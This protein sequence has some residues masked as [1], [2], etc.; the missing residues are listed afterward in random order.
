M[1]S[2]FGSNAL[3][4]NP[5]NFATLRLRCAPAPSHLRTGPIT[6]R[7][8]WSEIVAVVIVGVTAL[9]VDFMVFRASELKN[10]RRLAMTTP[11][12]SGHK[13]G[14]ANI[15]NGTAAAAAP[16]AAAVVDCNGA[17]A[18]QDLGGVGD[19]KPGGGAGDGRGANAS[20]CNVIDVR[21]ATTT[22]GRSSGGGGTRRN[23]VQMRRVCVLAVWIACAVVFHR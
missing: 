12:P 18:T 2:L 17:T 4:L 7:F 21:L 9:V 11:A 14:S 6:L 23:R 5:L 13:N 3:P 15:A 19:K 22:V 1:D 8:G 10:I 20:S 16:V